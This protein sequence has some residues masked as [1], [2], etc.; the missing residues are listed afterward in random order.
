M[1]DDKKVPNNQIIEVSNT[2][3]KEVLMTPKM[4][5]Y[6]ETRFVLLEKKIKEIIKEHDLNEAATYSLAEH[7]EQLNEQLSSVTLE[8]AIKIKEIQDLDKSLNNDDSNKS[9]ITSERENLI[10]NSSDNTVIEEPDI[11]ERMVYRQLEFV[12]T[13]ATENLY[14]Y[15]LIP[16][17]KTDYI[18]FEKILCK[19]ILI[20][21]LD[22]KDNDD[23]QFFF[24]TFTIDK[25]TTFNDIIKS[26][27]D[28]WDIN[29]DDYDLKFCMQF[30]MVANMLSWILDI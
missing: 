4:K 7:K 14:K 12:L 23:K 13:D 3:N 21:L 26:A 15:N 20:I 8:L 29:Y 2:E 6:Y 10:K 17:K 24:Q 27:C 5:E 22:I 25:L 18:N 28:L 11:D 19:S 16:A 9:L 1:T 30:S